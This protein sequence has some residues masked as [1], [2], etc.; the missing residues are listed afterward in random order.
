L[1]LAVGRDLAIEI[2]R[3]VIKILDCGVEYCNV[4][5]PNVLCNPE[6]TNVVLVDF[7][8]SRILKQ[9][10]VLQETSPNRKRKHFHLNLVS[11]G[12]CFDQSDPHV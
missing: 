8:R 1:I 7:E 10:Q 11:P 5:P 4:R 3:A 12:M 9:E 6:N 2:S